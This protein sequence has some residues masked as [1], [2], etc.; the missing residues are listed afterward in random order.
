MKF[1]STNKQAGTDH[2]EAFAAAYSTSLA[3]GHDPSCY[4]YD[5]RV[6]RKHLI[7]CF[8][9]RMIQPFIYLFIYL[10]ISKTQKGKTLMYKNQFSN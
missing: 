10:L 1:A 3:Y 4:V 6:M 7:K 2:C 8:E 9:E 5:H